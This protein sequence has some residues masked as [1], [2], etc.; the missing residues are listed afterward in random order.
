MK[1]KRDKVFV[2]F[3]S[4]FTP[5]WKTA[6]CCGNIF[7]L[8]PRLGSELV[9]FQEGPP[10][11]SPPELNEAQLLRFDIYR[12]AA[13]KKQTA[14]LII[15]SLFLRSRSA[16]AGEE[17]AL[18]QVSMEF[19]HENL[20]LLKSQTPPSVVRAFLLLLLVVRLQAVVIS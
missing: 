8:V 18:A 17:C 13:E 16:G 15:P 9:V 2:V 6:S 12:A 4:E 3:A 10:K 5:G 1:K 19:D 14:N 20:I 7:P 11:S